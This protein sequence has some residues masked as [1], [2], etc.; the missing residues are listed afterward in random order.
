MFQRHCVDSYVLFCVCQ[1]T[2]SEA[3]LV[4]LLAARRKTVRKIQ[5]SNPALS[6]GEVFGKLVSYTSEQVSIESSVH[7]RLSQV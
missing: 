2:A 7:S 3:T 4:A 1:S 5:A 6:E